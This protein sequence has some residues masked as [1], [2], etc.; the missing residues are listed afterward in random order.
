VAYEITPIAGFPAPELPAF[1][2]S[3]QWQSEGTAVGPRTVQVVNFETDPTLVHVSRGTG[4]KA[5][6]ITVNA[7]APAGPFIGWFDP[8]YTYNGVVSQYNEGSI[9]LNMA[10]GI[11]EGPALAC[12]MVG[13]RSNV[14]IV[15]NMVWFPTPGSPGDHDPGSY[16]YPAQDALVV[17][18]H[19]LNFG[20]ILGYG[21]IT[22]SIDGTP[23]VNALFFQ[24]TDDDPVNGTVTWWSNTP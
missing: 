14:P 13:D 1:P 15:W 24:V 21:Y 5:N 20:Q 2:L 19:E 8:A 4:E 17:Y 22:A 11:A 16:E 12:A 10:G 23:A 9:S 7:L 6:V 18:F 3:L